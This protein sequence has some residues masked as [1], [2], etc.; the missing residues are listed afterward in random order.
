MVVFCRIFCSLLCEHGNDLMTHVSSFHHFLGRHLHSELV[1]F[2]DLAHTRKHHTLA[3]GS[4]YMQLS[5][6]TLH[7]NGDD[8]LHF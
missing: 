5:L 3:F 7:G 1:A 6:L 8:R 4:E 2:S